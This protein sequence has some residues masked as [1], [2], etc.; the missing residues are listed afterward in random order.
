MIGAGI[1][2]VLFSGAASAAPPVPSAEL[3]APVAGEVRDCELDDAYFNARLDGALERRIS[4][5][6]AEMRC[7][8]MRRPDGV[9]IRLS[10]AGDAARA[11]LVFVFGVPQLGEGASGTALP[12]NVTVIHE[13]GALYGT[14]GADKCLLDHVEQTPLPVGAG[15]RRWRIAARGFCLEPARAVGAAPARDAILLATFDFV[16][17]LTWDEGSRAP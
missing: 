5:H 11:H 8:G 3:P 15:G 13:G 10:F 16:G 2:A 17:L 4:W 1:L 7:T 9:G 6:A 14:Q 12:V